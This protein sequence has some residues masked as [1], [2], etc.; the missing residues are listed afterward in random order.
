MTRPESFA[1]EIW[2]LQQKMDFSDKLPVL[3]SS[4]QKQK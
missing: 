1:A 4:C 2:K 3:S